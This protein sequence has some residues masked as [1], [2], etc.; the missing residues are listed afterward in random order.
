MRMKDLY[1]RQISYLRLSV[2]EHCN[3][4]CRYCM[5][6]QEMCFRKQKSMLSEDEMILAVQAA[7]SV[8]IS[9]LRITGGEPLTS[10]NILS[11]CRRAADVEGI[12]EIC[13]T[14]NGILLDRMAE[15]LA[16]A[17]VKRI[18]I[19]LD[20]LSEEKY[21]YITGQGRLEDAQRGVQAALEAG[22]E[23]IKINVVLIGGFNDDEIRPLAELTRRWPV[24]V[25]FIE[26]MPM[27]GQGAFS[28]RAYL[29]VSA[30]LEKLPELVLQPPDGGV[31]RLYRL[32]QAQ[33]NVGLISPLSAHFCAQCNRLRLTSDGMLKPCLHSAREWSVKGMDFTG[34]QKVF[35]DAIRSKPERH[36]R[37]DAHTASLAGRSMYQIG[38]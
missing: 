18:N 37:L 2:T 3:L 30:V 26:L 9:K 4:R 33:G 6:G 19:S 17:G 29:P 14:T 31:A 36:G 20:T 12:R 1:G 34:V 15:P 28:E 23:K 22:F 16:K 35:V 8:G 10:P 21:S 27:H 32:P 5:P 24:D 7:A 25:R 13:L 11:L 38:G